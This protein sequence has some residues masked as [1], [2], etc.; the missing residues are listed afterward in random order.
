MWWIAGGRQQARSRRRR[1]GR[2]EQEEA[3]IKEVRR[4]GRELFNKICEDRKLKPGPKYQNL[5]PCLSLRR[6]PQPVR[7]L[8]KSAAEVLNSWWVRLEAAAQRLLPMFLLLSRSLLVHP[9]HFTQFKVRSQRKYSYP[10]PINL[11]MT[12]SYSGRPLGYP[13][14]FSSLSEFKWAKLHGGPTVCFPSSI[15]LSQTLI[16]LSNTV[17][18]SLKFSRFYCLGNHHHSLWC[19]GQLQACTLLE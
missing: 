3:G 11:W 8:M 18:C 5:S 12:A 19:F 10:R 16:C 13:A 1:R 7:W 4:G 15:C 6:L 14:Q 2:G 9:L 17:W